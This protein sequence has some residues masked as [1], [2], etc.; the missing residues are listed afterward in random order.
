LIDDSPSTSIVQD[1]VRIAIFNAGDYSARIEV[2]YTFNNQQIEDESSSKIEKGQHRS[3]F[4]PKTATSI[5]IRVR[6]SGIFQKKHIINEQIPDLTDSESLCYL[7][8]YTSSHPVYGLC[9]ST[10]QAMVEAWGTN[11]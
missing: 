5:H 10:Y 6:E 4:L 7:L 9:P 2:N 8:A 1:P 11:G 3:I